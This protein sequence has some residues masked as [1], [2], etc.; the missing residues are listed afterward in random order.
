MNKKLQMKK[1][2]SLVALITISFNSFAQVSVERNGDYPIWDCKNFSQVQFMWVYYS[3]AKDGHFEIVEAKSGKTL[4]SDALL[5][6]LA[7]IDRFDLPVI[8][9][10]VHKDCMFKTKIE[11]YHTFI[12]DVGLISEEDYL[13]FYDYLEII[14]FYHNAV[15]NAIVRKGNTPVTKYNTKRSKQY[16]KRKNNYVLD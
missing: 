5:N 3:F 6:E 2:L 8:C 15:W 16:L 10:K 7:Q 1:I 13:K 4:G 14:H 9:E 12:N 11:L